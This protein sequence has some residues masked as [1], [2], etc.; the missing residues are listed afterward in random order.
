MN[1]QAHSI[2]TVGV[3]VD[4]YGQYSDVYNYV[5][6][7]DDLGGEDSGVVTIGVGIMDAIDYCVD[8]YIEVYDFEISG[9]EKY[10]D[11]T[12]DGIVDGESA[13]SINTAVGESL[14][15]A[16]TSN[17]VKL[18]FKGKSV[19]AETSDLYDVVASAASTVVS[20][21]SGSP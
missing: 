5:I 4:S 21:G 7:A 2:A 15:D 19:S 16:S 9:D 20:G 1:G 18:S 10:D 11:A 6:S 3:E 12:N 17:T 8:S 13:Y 14:Y